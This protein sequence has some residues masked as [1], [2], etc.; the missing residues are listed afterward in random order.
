MLRCSYIILIHNN[1][2]NITKLIESLKKITGN[3]YKEFIFI[4]DGSTDNSLK[5]LKSVV[6]DIPRTTIITQERQGPTI[7]INKAVSLATG[8]YIQFVSGGEILHPDSTSIL[9]DACIN[10]GTDVAVGL[11]SSQEITTDKDNV[12]NPRD[13]VKLI[14]NPIEE[15][16]GGKL[17]SIANIGKSASTVRRDLL[18]KIEKADNSIY[19]QNMSL[20]LRC[21]KY[22]KFAYINE[23]IVSLPK[24][25]EEFDPRFIK[26]NNLKSIYNFAKE[27]PEIFSKLIPELLKVLGRESSGRFNKINY[28]M[29]AVTAKYVKSSSLNQVL[30]LYKQELDK[31]F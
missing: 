21:A 2:E 7:S 8:E 10:R 11:V 4:D 5:I 17:S 3:F 28:A 31:L 18:E 24:V 12:D 22:S 23:Y 6:A 15:I 29:K 25:E 26:Y 1:Q 20:S 16:L 27:N 9:I 13:S 30:E 19:T 14:S